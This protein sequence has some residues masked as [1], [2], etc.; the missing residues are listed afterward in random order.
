MKKG[1]VLAVLFLLSVGLY[2]NGV[3]IKLGYKNIGD[4]FHYTENLRAEFIDDSALALSV[5]DGV[6]TFPIQNSNANIRLEYDVE[7]ASWDNADG[8]TWFDLGPVITMPLQNGMKA[9]AKIKFERL[10]NDYADRSE[11]KWIPFITRRNNG[12]RYTGRAGMI[13]RD[14]NDFDG[15]DILLGGDM[16]WDRPVNGFRIKAAGQIRD[17]EDGDTEIKLEGFANYKKPLNQKGLFFTLKAAP[18]LEYQQV[19]SKG[20]IFNSSGGFDIEISQGGDLDDIDLDGL[21]LNFKIAAG[22]KFYLL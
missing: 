7:L 18:R 16:V 9:G 20:M 11:F 13:F 15:L 2:G 10:N 6:Y 19:V 22:L 21:N 1:L 4:K 14:Y 8:A 12:I 5:E 3:K 17:Y